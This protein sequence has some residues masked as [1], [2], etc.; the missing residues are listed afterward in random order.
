MCWVL[1]FRQEATVESKRDSS[2]P[3][4]DYLLVCGRDSGHTDTDSN[5]L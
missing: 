5:V 3:H 1:F 2:C 4:S